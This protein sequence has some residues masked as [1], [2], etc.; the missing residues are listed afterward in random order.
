M[1]MNEVIGP[2]SASDVKMKSGRSEINVSGGVGE[3][4]VHIATPLRHLRGNVWGGNDEWRFG[5]ARPEGAQLMESF[6]SVNVLD[7]DC[8]LLRLLRR[9]DLDQSVGTDRGVP[10]E[11]G[12]PLQDPSG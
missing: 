10:M 6:E 4:Q 8:E 5:L 7:F 9:I 12:L 11:L 1:S 2:A 3:V